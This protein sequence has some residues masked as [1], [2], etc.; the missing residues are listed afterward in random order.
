M[1]G[2]VEAREQVGDADHLGQ[3]DDAVVAEALAQAR[4]QRLGRFSA[5]ARDMLGKA[6][7]VFFQFVEFAALLV[8][9]QGGDLLFPNAHGLGRGGVVGD[10]ELA[11]GQHRGFQVRQFPVFFLQARVSHDLVEKSG[12][13]LQSPGPT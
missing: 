6:Q 4:Q 3:D 7:D 10:A 8:G 1:Q 2:V 9:V 12:K 13:R 11:A 5:F